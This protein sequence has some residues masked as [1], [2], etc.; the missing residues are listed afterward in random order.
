[1]HRYA[2][3]AFVLVMAAH[4]AREWVLGHYRHYRTVPWLTGVPLVALAFVCAVGGFWLNWDRLGQ[5][6]VVSTAEWLDALPFL[7]S[8]LARNFLGGMSLGDRLITDCP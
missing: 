3:D 2:A 6:S 4:I 8:P 7:A 1:V 5:Y